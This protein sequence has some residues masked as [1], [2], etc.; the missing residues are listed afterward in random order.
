MLVTSAQ[1]PPSPLLHPEPPPACCVCTRCAAAWGILLPRPLLTTRSKGLPTPTRVIHVTSLPVFLTSTQTP[2]ERTRTV[3][4]VYSQTPGQVHM[5]WSRTKSQSLGG[6]PGLRG[7]TPGQTR[8]PQSCAHQVPT[9]APWTGC[10]GRGT[11][12]SGP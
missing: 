10:A 12:R 4:L 8:L 6:D 2:Q 9:S 11:G 1:S 3:S 7:V 5:Q